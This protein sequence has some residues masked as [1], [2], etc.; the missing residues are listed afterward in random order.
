MDIFKFK[1]MEPLKKNRWILKLIGT[2]IPEYIF[3]E[4]KIYNEDSKMIFET[5]FI[6]CV[7]FQY[8]PKDLFNIVGVD[9]KYLDHTGVD[10]GGI[11][12]YVKEVNFEKKCSYKKNGLM[13]TKLKFT[14]KS[15]TIKTINKK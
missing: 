5:Q 6:E 1:T 10:V 11:F 9:I 4:Y 3:T 2:D 14:I 15:E 7:E 8:N 13:K 12:F